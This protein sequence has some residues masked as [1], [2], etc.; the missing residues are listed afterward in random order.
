MRV[1]LF[2]LSLSLFAGDAV[3]E[4][5]YSMDELEALAVKKNYTELMLA[6]PH[7]IPAEKGKSWELLVEK[8]AIGQLSELYE[9]KDQAVILRA[10][11]IVRQFPTLA[12]SEKFRKAK[13]N[14]TAE[15]LRDCYVNNTDKKSC[16]ELAGYIFGTEADDISLY[17]TIAPVVETGA[18]KAAVF[19]VYGRAIH[20]GNRDVLCQSNYLKS[21]LMKAMDSAESKVATKSASEFIESSCWAVLE[22]EIYSRLERMPASD[23]KKNWCKIVKKKNARVPACR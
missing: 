6:L 8:A 20:I 11:A 17:E 18:G 22:K 14:E 15:I 19:Q 2:F 10:K 23:A 5:Y 1:L 21:A 13:Q 9:K 4:K 16:T 3:E 7:V 12:H